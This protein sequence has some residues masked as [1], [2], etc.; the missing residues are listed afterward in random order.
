M[1]ATPLRRPGGVS[2]PHVVE[3]ARRA[4]ERL[5]RRDPFWP[6]QLTVLLAIVLYVSLP[7]K[8]TLGPGW[9]VPAFEGALL[10]GLVIA[11]PHP[12]VIHSP[13][14]RHL[15]M[16][17]VGLVSAVNLASLILLVHYLLKGGKAD[18]HA[19]ILAGIVL[20]VTNVLT[21]A[22]WF[23]EL[24]RGGPVARYLAPESLPDFLFPQMTE[25]HLAPEGWRPG[26]L[27]YLYV[28][29]TNATAFSPTDTMP[30]TAVAKTLMS[31]QSIAALVTIGLVVAR[32]VNILN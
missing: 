24:D 3:R 30:L 25:T 28:S 32:A 1:S 18:G 4:R 5:D 12:K 13:R 31:V 7:A 17:L 8:L 20:W 11:T 22:L 23:W 26:F 29:F 15:A 16:G 2:A 9:L 10:L 14:R 21:F 19:L 27:D 6:A